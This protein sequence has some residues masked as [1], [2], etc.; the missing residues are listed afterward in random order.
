MKLKSYS[1]NS[2]WF[3]SPLLSSQA[4]SLAIVIISATINAETI[5]NEME[6]RLTQ[7]SDEY[8]YSP[9]PDFNPTRA[10]AE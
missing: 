6:D 9:K 10:H 2:I 7:H 3:S 5:Y 8:V 4:S 1:K